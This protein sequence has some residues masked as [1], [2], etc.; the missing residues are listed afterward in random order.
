MI[1]L[2]GKALEM[3][4]ESKDASSNFFV[5]IVK[6]VLTAVTHLVKVSKEAAGGCPWGHLGEGS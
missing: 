6:E 5:F 4:L 1:T 2:G 3:R